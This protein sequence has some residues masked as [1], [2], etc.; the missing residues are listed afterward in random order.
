[1]DLLSRS[2]PAVLMAA[3][4][5]SLFASCFSRKWSHSRHA[6]FTR[7]LIFCMLY[8]I[9]FRI[10]DVYSILGSLADGQFV[11]QDNFLWLLDLIDEFGEHFAD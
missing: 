11:L 2:F 8:F 9:A 6:H 10:N 4:L 7:A 3:F 5:A 1:M